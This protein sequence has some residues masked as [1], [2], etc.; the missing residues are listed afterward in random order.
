M[1]T[2]T[3]QNLFVEGTSD[4]NSVF[5]LKS[6]AVKDGTVKDTARESGYT[7]SRLKFT[8]TTEHTDF[9]DKHILVIL[10]DAMYA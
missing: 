10:S 8:I 1:N 7:F 6:F 3:A 4:P 5:K 9:D 2:I